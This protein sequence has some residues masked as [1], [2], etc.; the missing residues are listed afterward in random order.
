MQKRGREE[1]KE[2]K[3]ERRRRRR[4]G[5]ASYPIQPR[6]IKPRQTQAATWPAFSH[7]NPFFFFSSDE[8]IFSGIVVA[9]VVVVFFCFFFR[10]KSSLRDSISMYMPCGKSAILDVNN[11]WKLSP[12]TQFLDPKSSLLDS[13][14]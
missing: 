2:R 1:K 10:C 7:C 4:N 6:K 9:V 12:K 14:C 11:P 8:H 13:K 5:D 3:R